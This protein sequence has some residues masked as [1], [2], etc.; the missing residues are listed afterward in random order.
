MA[1]L[2]P[3]KIREKDISRSSNTPKVIGPKAVLTTITVVNIL[4]T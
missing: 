4:R 3:A 1:A 2:T